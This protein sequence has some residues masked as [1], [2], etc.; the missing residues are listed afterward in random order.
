MSVAQR[1]QNI[2]KNIETVCAQNRR[3]PDS[4][5]LLAVSKLHPASM[6]REAYG[7]GQTNF[8]ENYIQEALEKQRELSD[9]KTLRWH[10]IGRIQ[11]NKIKFLAANFC[12][13]HSVDRPEIL[14]GINKACAKINHVQ[15]IFLQLNI[16]GEASKG[17]ASVS[18][19]EHLLT[20]A[21]KCDNVRVL[22]LMVMPP[23]G[24]SADAARPFFAQAKKILVEK[25]AL[26]DERHP[27][28]ELSMGTSHDY[29]AAIAEGSTWVRIGTDIFG[30]REEKT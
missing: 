14:R 28:N 19:L 17:G 11:S 24:E 26:L 29:T 25:R 8:A 7:A 21:S 15:D 10:F 9:L 27:F 30:L 4:V 5:G 6:V 1:L 22:G 3:T 18:D 23:L 20:E 2:K 13:I 12:V 16:A